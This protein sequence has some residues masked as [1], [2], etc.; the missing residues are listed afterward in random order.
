MASPTQWTWV[1][2]NSGSLWWTGRPC[3]LQSMGSQRAR[4]DW[5]TELNWTESLCWGFPDSSADKESTCSAGDP[6][7]I[8]GPG[9]SPGGGHG[10]PLQYSC[11]QNP[12]DRGPWQA[13][14]RGSHRVG[15]DLAHTQSHRLPGAWGSPRSKLPVDQL[16]TESRAGNRT[17]LIS[18]V[19]DLF[20]LSPSTTQ[21][22]LTCLKHTHSAA[23]L[24]SLSEF[25]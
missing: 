10:N 3:V 21:R 11:L 4:H 8:P 22:C 19:R 9:R 18:V 16:C 25:S 23:T 2:V 13:T 20:S 14:V 17:S 15:Q 12:M 7:L 6:S 5:V 24:C 1:W